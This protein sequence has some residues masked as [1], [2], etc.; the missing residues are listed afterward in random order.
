M[1]KILAVL[2]LCS[3]SLNIY[4]M[5]ADEVV[6]DNFDEGADLKIDKIKVAQSAIKPVCPT[7]QEKVIYECP[8]ESNIDDS[9]EEKS[10]E[11]ALFDEVAYEDSQRQ[12][13]RKITEYLE[14]ELRL[15]QEKIDQFHQLKT[16]REQELGELFRRQFEEHKQKYGDLDSQESGRVIFTDPEDTIAVGKINLKYE[17][18]LLDLFGIESTKQYQR[19]KYL[20]NQNSQNFFVEF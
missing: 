10:H 13:E 11:D 3:L 2:L 16:M 14:T 1:K 19:Y 4:F 20:H 8:L 5:N 6:V 9:K 18:K 12:W 7:P 15:P 17:K